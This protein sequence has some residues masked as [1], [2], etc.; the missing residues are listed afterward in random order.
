M[1]R[2]TDGLSADPIA[3][4]QAELAA[5][6]PAIERAI[7]QT[8]GG[9]LVLELNLH[10]AMSRVSFRWHPTSELLREDAGSEVC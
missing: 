7:A 6:R 1:R 10:P 5:R 2:S 4:L 9:P 3:W 8:E